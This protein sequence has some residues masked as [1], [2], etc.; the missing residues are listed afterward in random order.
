MLQ[1][2]ELAQTCRLVDWEKVK[3]KQT[4]ALQKL[5]KRVYERSEFYSDKLN[6]AGIKPE[7]IRSVDDLAYLPFTTKEEL[8]QYPLEYL[9][10]A[11]E[12]EIVRI[13]SS[14]GTTG[15]PVIIPYTMKDVHDTAEFMARCMRMAGV[16]RTDRVQ[17]TPGF[18]LW[19]AG[20]AFQSGV[21]K[22][23][24]MAIPMGPGNT[25]KQLEMM[26]ELRAT[27][28]TATASY[29]LLLAEEVKRRGLRDKLRLRIGIFGSERW[30]EK[31]RQQ[32]AENLGIDTFD[33]YGLTEVYGPG[34]ALDCPLHTG[35]HYWDDHLIF[36]IIDP[37]TGKVLPPGEEGELVITTLSKEGLPLLRYRTHDITRLLPEACPCGSSHL[38][39]GRILGRSDE[40]FKVKGVMVY[41]GQID[42]AIK[43]TPGAGSE[44][45]VIL[46]KQNAKDHILVRLEGEPGADP[47][48]VAVKC[49]QNIKRIIGIQAE[50][51]VVPYGSLPR[52]EKKTKRIFD[53]RPT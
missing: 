52:S 4:P 41:P 34:I 39:I 6:Q 33:I 50:V 11:S 43:E 36:E 28:L 17:I 51:E 30:G 48:A 46:T 9:R 22:V 53:N 31:M 14:S 19:T 40:A 47:E 16:T 1:K 26:V 7:D 5:V 35:L 15:K 27:V 38:M 20:L 29:A 24:A 25:E 42:T 23:G 10:A 12:E 49:K 45:Q 18:G 21:E 2:A 13:H 3:E 37:L 8:R 32:I 44:Y